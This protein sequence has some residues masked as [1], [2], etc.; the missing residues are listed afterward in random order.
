MVSIVVIKETSKK[1]NKA[2]AEYKT[3]S[4]SAKD[5]RKE[6]LKSRSEYAAKLKKTVADTEIKSKIKVERQRDQTQR[7]HKQIRPF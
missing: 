5:A 4:K 2:C 3:L 7:R 1:Y 6:F